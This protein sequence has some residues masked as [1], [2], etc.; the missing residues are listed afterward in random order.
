[1]VYDATIWLVVLT[2][3]KI[4]GVRQCGGWQPNIWNGKK[5][6]MFQTTNQILLTIINIINH[7]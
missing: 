2:S 5:K 7:H 1:M 3:L 6:N 4:L